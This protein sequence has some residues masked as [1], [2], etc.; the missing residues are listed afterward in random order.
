M[1]ARPRARR[2]TPCAPPPPPALR[3]SSVGAYGERRRAESINRVGTKSIRRGPSA[4]AR[5]HPPLAGRLNRRRAGMRCHASNTAIHSVC[6]PVS[7]AIVHLPAP[8]VE[9]ERQLL[10]LDLIP[11]ERD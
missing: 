6:Q 1:P 5:A 4:S 3:I 9:R 8:V 10:G 11:R 2:A 7:L